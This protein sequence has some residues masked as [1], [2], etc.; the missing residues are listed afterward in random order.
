MPVS[1]P[2]PSG[3]PA[4]K[5]ERWS[6]FLPLM[7]EE[8]H[9][10]GY[11]LPLPFGAS[12]IYNYLERDIDIK[13][14]RIGV[15]GAPPGSVS[16]FV[17]LGSTSHVNVGLGRFDAW[18]LPFLNVYALVG[19]IDNESATRGTVTIPLPGPIPGERTFTFTADT[20]I[21]GVVGG[22]GLTLAAGFKDF[23]LMADANYTQTDL[24][25][26]DSFRA[27]VASMRAGWN[28][29]ISGVPTRFWAGVMYWDTSNTARATV[30]VPDV[31]LVSFEADQGPK[32]PT[33]AS[34]GAQV[35]LAEHWDVMA[36]YGF[37]FDDVKVF[38]TGVTYR[39]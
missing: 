34:I 36:E 23:F 22:G 17:D 8:A 3:E 27:L 19:Y 4:P 18:L 37:N 31:G 16:N 25:F 1:T 13:D 5:P 32:N 35:A 20:S 38:V 33:N 28:G 24:G 12:A 29:R 21:Q 2:A 39:F 7:A 10:R 14:L 9:K 15:D 26:D 11:E 30:E 6:S